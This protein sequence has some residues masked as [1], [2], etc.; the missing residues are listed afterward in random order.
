MRTNPDLTETIL[1][2][3]LQL[4][5]TPTRYRPSDRRLAIELQARQIS[6][7]VIE[8]AFLLSTLR[9]LY[10]SRDLPALTPIRSL[11]YFMPTIDE[12]LH[13]TLSLGYI[14]YLRGK[15]RKFTLNG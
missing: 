9:R 12:L 10:R 2:L 13:Q 11:A 3:Y 6:I 14:D 7:E 5:H 15:F 8:S 4:P 1:R